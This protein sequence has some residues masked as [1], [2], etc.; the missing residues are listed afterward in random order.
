[1]R[2]TKRGLVL[3]VAL[4]A[5]IPLGACRDYGFAP[6]L[7]PVFGSEAAPCPALAGRWATSNDNDPFVM[8]PG[9]DGSRLAWALPW[10]RAWVSVEAYD[11]EGRRVARLLTEEGAR[12]RAERKVRLDGMP[13][14]LYVVVLRAKSE[15]G[16]ASVTVSR[17]MRI[18]GEAP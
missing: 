11:L 2:F 15:E 3:P 12:G 10:P 5:V 1:M 18:E 17:A 9:A 14:G 4:A 13:A 7:H 16:S 8:R 6:S